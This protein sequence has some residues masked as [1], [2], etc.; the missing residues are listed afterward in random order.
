MVLVFLRT[1]GEFPVALCLLAALGAAPA[2]ANPPDPL[3]PLLHRNCGFFRRNELA[4]ITLDSRYAVNPSE[5]IRLSVVSQ[6]LAYNELYHADQLEGYR[7]DIV[8]RADFLLVHFDEILSHSAF[9]GMLGYA[10]LG[11]YEITGD[12]RYLDR[13]AAIVSRC[14]RLRGFQITLNWGLMA[15][16]ALAKYHQLTGDADALAKTRAIV[17]SLDF[18]QHAD[19]S[20]PHYCPSSTDVHYT[21][22]MAMELMH[23]ARYVDDPRIQTQLEGI[24]R[25]LSAR[26]GPDG[27]TRYQEPC[28]DR[29]NCWIYHYSTA[30]GCGIDYDTRAWNN[31]LGYNAMVFDRFQDAPYHD[32]MGFLYTLEHHGSFAD[33]WDFF[34]PPGDPLYV[35]ASNDASVIR[36][37]VIFWSLASMYRDR[38][39][40]VPRRYDDGGAEIQPAGSVGPASESAQWPE[41]LLPAAAAG[42][43]E[44]WRR[45]RWSTV[46]SLVLADADPEEI[47]RASGPTQETL[48]RQRPRSD[49]GH[50]VAGGRMPAVD[51]LAGGFPNPARGMASLEFHLAKAAEISL[52]IYDAGGRLVRELASGAWAS[53]TH[54]VF[55]N[56]RDGSGGW[57]RS[58]T[59]FYKLTVNGNVVSSE[60]AVFLAQ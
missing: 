21:G 51:Q 3:L 6:L 60:K 44:A 14:M 29:R 8:A 57:V 37:S 45:F 58:G 31:E 7:A 56:G 25:Y 13:A 39:A 55:W 24:H 47:C 15:G 35:W 52:A 26:V 2:A 46:D 16:M 49:S 59:Y 43:D 1:M 20:F 27:R 4:G 54:R 9:D 40:P 48:R 41:P 19:G 18:Y 36:T 23:I 17:Q 38:R 10:L 11:A 33:K 22:W 5:V 42:E 28:P 50:E 32:V 30:S 34:V 53:G 12:C